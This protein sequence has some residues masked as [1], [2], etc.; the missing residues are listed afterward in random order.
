MRYCFVLCLVFFFGCGKK[1]AD[2][3]APE[4]KLASITRFGY[5]IRSLTYA[6][7]KIVKV[8][9]DSSANSV[10]TYGSTGR[11]TKIEVPS[12]YPI[13]KTELF[14][15]DEG[16]ISMEKKYEK[17]GEPN[18][19]ENTVFFFTYTNGKVTA[20]RE[21]FQL[22]SPA[23]EFNHE[24]IWDGNNIRSII[25]RSGATIIC[26]QQ[27]SYDT[28]Q[29]NP[30]AAF[31]DLYYGDYLQPSFKMP[32]YFSA[33]MLIKEDANCP[34]VQTTNITYDLS[35][36]L[37]VKVFTDGNEYLAYNYECR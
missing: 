31:I 37:H 1:Q 36:S 26:T 10:L 6:G 20:I 8:G 29:K 32:L 7:T 2:V 12:A 27:Y 11:L 14:Y 28:T 25:I 17:R 3:K 30:V 35:D 16:K 23:L 9:D 4:C 19:V 24:V 13:Y 21:T 22:V 18:W 33:D 15:N 5:D 34:S